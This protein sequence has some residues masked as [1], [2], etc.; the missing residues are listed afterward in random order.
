MPHL[1]RIAVR[2]YSRIADFLYYLSIAVAA[3]FGLD[4]LK[5]GNV[6]D[7]IWAIVVCT[8]ICLLTAVADDVKA[9]RGLK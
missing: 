2:L 6:W 1:V 7:F 3:A 5:S 9:K 4:I 8:L